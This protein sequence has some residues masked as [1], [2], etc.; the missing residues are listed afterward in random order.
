M[1]HGVRRFSVTADLNVADP[2][3]EDILLTVGQP[4]S[5]H[6][7]GAINFGP[8]GYLYVPLGDGGSGSDPFDLGQ[9][10]TTI[11]G[12]ITRIDVDSGPGSAPDCSGVGSGNYTVPASN[13]LVDGAGGTCD[14][15]WALGLR[16]PW[17]SS[18]DRL[19]GDLWIGDVGQLTWEEVDRQP[20]ASAGGENYGW[21]CYEGNH[22]FNLAGCGPI[23]S[24][25]FPV[26]EYAHSGNGCSVTGGYV[27]RGSQ[28]PTL[29][30]RYLLADYCTGN[31]WDLAPSRRGGY[32]ATRHTELAAFGYVAF[33]EVSSRACPTSA[34]IRRS[35]PRRNAIGT[36]R[37]RLA[38]PPADG[39]GLRAGRHGC[40]VLSGPR[41]SRL[42]R[43]AVRSGRPRASGPACR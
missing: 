39:S 41:G 25:D 16:N 33:G 32:T 31:F 40:S 4:F 18:F 2:A 43:R 35:A 30:G 11:L 28:F 29:A 12:K 19:T 7:A 22:P 3:S 21:R 37:I 6:N 5:N 27:Y 36:K 26:F 20:A 42:G 17:R 1:A 13:P 8:D 15:I 14:E 24:Y 38:L 34:L 10:P 9:S 23:G